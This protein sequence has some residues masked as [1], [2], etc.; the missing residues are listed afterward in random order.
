MPDIKNFY[1]MVMFVNFAGMAGTFTTL[2]Q[3]SGAGYSNALRRRSLRTSVPTTH[4]QSKGPPYWYKLRHRRLR[5]GESSPSGLRRTINDIFFVLKQ[6]I[7]YYDLYFTQL[8]LIFQEWLELG[9]M[10]M[11]AVTPIFNNFESQL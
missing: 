3:K 4:T 8:S 5:Q 9:N 6:L 11:L 2:T 7:L 1:H 10:Q